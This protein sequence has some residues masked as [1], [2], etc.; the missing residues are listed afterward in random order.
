[1]S[2]N[3][4]IGRTVAHELGHGTFKLRHT[5]DS[6]YRIAK[7][8]TDNLMDYSWGTELVKHQWDAIH[9]PGLVIGLFEKDEDAMNVLAPTQFVVT[10]KD[11]NLQIND[12]LFVLN[13]F[14]QNIVLKTVKQIEKELI[15]NKITWI[16]RGSEQKSDSLTIKMDDMKD[17]NLVIDVKTTAVLGKVYQASITLIKLKVD[18]EREIIRTLEEL[19][20]IEKSYN[21]IVSSIDQA[22]K[23]MEFDPFLIKGNNNRYV[24]RGMNR[25]FENPGDKKTDN[26]IDGL[27]SQLYATDLLMEIYEG[28]FEKMVEKIRTIIQKDPTGVYQTEN[29]EFIQKVISQ[30][31]EIQHKDMEQTEQLYQEAIRGITLKQLIEDE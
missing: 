21:D 19:L 17:D 25:L 11:T 29:K 10:Y 6:E 28:N 12:T 7:A 3:E 9:A 4:I 5:F 22:V 26:I 24:G 23:K 13:G 18:P 27:F 31:N 20:D 14:H 30:I 15:T 1:M 16:V 2:K 8:T